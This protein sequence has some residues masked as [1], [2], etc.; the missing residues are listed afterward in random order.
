MAVGW[1]V[2]FSLELGGCRIGSA[3][4]LRLLQLIESLVNYRERAWIAYSNN[5]TL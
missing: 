5:D 4:A 2:V 1:L 3:F